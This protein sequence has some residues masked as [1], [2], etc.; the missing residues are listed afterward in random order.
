M[1]GKVERTFAIVKTVCCRST[2]EATSTIASFKTASLR[3]I[4]RE[5]ISIA[6]TASD[7]LK[8]SSHFAKS[9][10][11]EKLVYFCL[12]PFLS[13]TDIRQVLKIG[14]RYK[15]TAKLQINILSRKC[16]IIIII[17]IIIIHHHHHHHHHLFAFMWITDFRKAYSRLLGEETSGNHQ[18]YRRGH[19]EITILNKNKGCEGVRQE[20]TQKTI[21]IKTLALCS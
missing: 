15:S 16:Y 11:R 10:K 19:L 1:A 5:R 17:I 8:F 3:F 6:F 9:V 14:L 12:I 13:S 21:L 4:I 2:L 20:L 7:R 18:A